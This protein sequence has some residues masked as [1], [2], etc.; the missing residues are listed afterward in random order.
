MKT[1]ER[2]INFSG[3]VL[4][5]SRASATAS[6]YA[7]HIQNVRSN[8]EKIEESSREISLD[9]HSS[10]QQDVK[11]GHYLCTRSRQVN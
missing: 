5:P 8:M 2:T 1:G 4:V 11:P 3:C 7:A 9:L 6:F 10:G